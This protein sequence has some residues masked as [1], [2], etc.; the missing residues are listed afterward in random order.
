MS[1]ILA[2]VP[3][4]DR[5][6]YDPQGTWATPDVQ[7]EMRADTRAMKNLPPIEGL[8][9]PDTDWANRDPPPR[10][11]LVPDWI[12]GEPVVTVLSGDGGLGKTY[13]ALQLA[14]AVVLKQPW[15]GLP[16]S[17]RQDRHQERAF[18]LLCEDS[19]AE[20]HR[21]LHGIVTAMG[22]SMSE[23]NGLT[24]VCR[25]GEVSDLV[26]GY[27]GGMDV[28]QLYEQ[29]EVAVGVQGASLIVLDSLHNLYPGNENSRTDAAFFMTAVRRLA[30]AAN[31][32][33]V[34]V[35]HPSVG[36]RNSGTGEAGSTAWRNSARAMLYLTKPQDST[37]ADVRVLEHRKQNYARADGK[38]E[39]RWT[40]GWYEPAQEI[41]PWEQKGRDKAAEQGYLAALDEA[42]AQ[43]HRLSATRNSPH[44]APRILVTL[45]HA[46]GLTVD[47]LAAAQRRL[48]GDRTLHIEQ[49]ADGSRHPRPCIVRTA[50]GTA[51]GGH[52]DA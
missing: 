7:R 19:K 9:F 23:L 13:L 33:V 5:A 4:E 44:Y 18:V 41:G 38:R 51:S 24:L 50:S 21:R 34:L 8:V 42:T 52:A 32:P 31:S 26:A 22:R 43:G 29:L 10:R 16:V 45:P 49:V 2:R 28:T 46:R 27:Q 1:A 6:P 12:P 11:W 40:E 37:D 39:L 47:D 30:M 25:A 35:A 15:L 20:A 3:L 17:I 48:L 36:G 14:V